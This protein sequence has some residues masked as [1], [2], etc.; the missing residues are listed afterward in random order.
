MIYSKKVM[1][2]YTARETLYWL[3]RKP[4]TPRERTDKLQTYLHHAET[5]KG[6]LLVGNIEAEVCDLLLVAMRAI[7]VDLQTLEKPNCEDYNDVKNNV[8]EVIRMLTSD[9]SETYEELVN[10]EDV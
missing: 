6:Y 8:M 10:G 5:T 1:E 7:H 4:Q 9:Y 2:V 3:G